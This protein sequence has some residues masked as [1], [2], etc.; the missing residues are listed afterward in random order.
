MGPGSLLASLARECGAVGAV[1]LQVGDFSLR[2]FLEAVEAAFLIEASI[3][4]DKLFADRHTQLFRWTD[5]PAFFE[6]P[7]ESAPVSFIAPW[8]EK[9]VPDGAAAIAV[10]LDSSPHEM[11]VGLVAK[12]LELPPVQIHADHRLLADLHLNSIQVAQLVTG[13]CAALAL[14]SHS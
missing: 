12:L 13:A 9:T 4:T 7:C 5:R 8:P 6:N 11:V 10:K 3:R 1:S 2:G 14:H